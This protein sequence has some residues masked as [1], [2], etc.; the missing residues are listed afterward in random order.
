MFPRG[1]VIGTVDRKQV[2]DFGLTQTADIRPAA[3]FDQLSEVFVV[4]TLEV[5]SP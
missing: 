3:E 2:G 1:L 4:V 5:D